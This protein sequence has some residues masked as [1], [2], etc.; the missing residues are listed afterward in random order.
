M[1]GDVTLKPCPFCGEK[2]N[3]QAH[4]IAEDAVVAFVHCVGCG[5]QTEH[6][7]DAYAPRAQAIAAWNQRAD[8]QVEPVAAQD[9]AALVSGLTEA[10]DRVMP[11]RVHDGPDYAEVYFADGTTHST[12]AMTMNPADWQAIADAYA[13]LRAH[14][15]R[16]DH[17]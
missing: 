9:V 12:Q 11:I 15:E 2:A 16:T 5:V 4:Q 13:A 14:F 6:F 3:Y 1:S 8:A 7:E 17:E 10:M